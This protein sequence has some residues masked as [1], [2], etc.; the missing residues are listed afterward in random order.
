MMRDDRTALEMDM[1]TRVQRKVLETLVKYG[2]QFNGSL[3]LHVDLVWN[4]R[5]FRNM[6]HIGLVE[7]HPYEITEAGRAALAIDG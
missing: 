1:I 2:P 3:A 4:S 6:E 7:G 5:V